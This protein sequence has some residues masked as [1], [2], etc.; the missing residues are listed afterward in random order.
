MVPRVPTKKS[1]FP[2]L[3]EETIWNLQIQGMNSALTCT[4]AATLIVT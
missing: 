2:K 4:L 1:I 3:S